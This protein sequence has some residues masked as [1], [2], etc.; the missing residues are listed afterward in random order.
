M[1]HLKFLSYLV[2]VKLVHASLYFRFIMI[3]E[4]EE[5]LPDKLDLLQREKMVNLTSF[6][7]SQTTL[8]LPNVGN[9]LTVTCRDSYVMALRDKRPSEICNLSGDSRKKTVTVAGI[10]HGDILIA[11]LVED[12]TI[13]ARVVRDLAG[14]AEELRI[15]GVPTPKKKRI[16]DATAMGQ[17]L[18]T[19]VLVVQEHKDEP[20]DEVQPE[21]TDLPNNAIQR[22]DDRLM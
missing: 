16:I 9:N 4:A 20:Q 5:G 15:K 1:L 7:S 11:S 13:S 6:D 18:R 19:A 14:L 10:R 8:S 3:I 21:D 12:V 2:F 17:L 22:Q